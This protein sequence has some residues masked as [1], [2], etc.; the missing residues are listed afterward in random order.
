[1]KELNKEVIVSMASMAAGYIGEKILQFLFP[2]SLKIYA[3]SF[4]K[5]V[6]KEINPVRK[7]P[8]IWEERHVNE[9]GE[10]G[11][12]AKYPL[13]YKNYKYAHH[14]GS[15]WEVN[16]TDEA[17]Q[18]DTKI[19]IY[20]TISNRPDTDYHYFYFK[21]K[22]TNID[23][24]SIDAYKRVFHKDDNIHIV[25]TDISNDLD[26]SCSG[27]T[28]TGSFYFK[29][30]IGDTINGKEV[31][32]EQIGLIFGRTPGEYIIQEAYISD[33]KINIKRCGC[34][35]IFGRCYDSKP[36]PTIKNP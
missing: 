17:V 11:F 30:K 36:S 14:S 22:F 7:L 15:T 4:C 29:S 26:Y 1:M 32:S 25:D 28:L 8:Q 5:R 16:V 10:R 6:P 12:D 2:D 35:Y 21:I 27:N 9:N 13:G 24:P 19:H 23:D 3:R 18:Q 31:G 33:K 34:C 20:N